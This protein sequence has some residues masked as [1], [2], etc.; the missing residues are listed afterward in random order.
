MSPSEI[1][2]GEEFNH[3]DVYENGCLECELDYY[4]GEDLKCTKTKNCHESENGVCIIC[5][6]EYEFG[7]RIDEFIKVYIAVLF[8]HTVLTNEDIESIPKRISLISSLIVL[9]SFVIIL[10]T[11][12]AHILKDCPL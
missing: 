3:C 7:L 11:S 5:K 4:K 8:I 9:F 12:S 1:Q 6:D 2:D 10:R